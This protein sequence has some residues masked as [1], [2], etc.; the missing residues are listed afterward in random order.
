MDFL[1]CLFLGGLPQGATIQNINK[2]LYEDEATLGRTSYIG[3]ESA[4][5][6]RNFIFQE[7]KVVR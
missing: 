6:V 4:D 2:T 5:P 1:S 7:L 3:K